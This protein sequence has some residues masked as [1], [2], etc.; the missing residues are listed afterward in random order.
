MSEL[1]IHWVREA[2][3]RVSILFPQTVHLDSLLVLSSS[4][5]L[6]A[7]SDGLVSGDNLIFYGPKSPELDILTYMQ[8]AM[9]A[10]DRCHRE[11]KTYPS[12]FGKGSDYS[13]DY[14]NP[15]TA[16][17]DYPIVTKLKLPTQGFAD[18]NQ[19]FNHLKA[20]GSWPGEPALY[21][22]SINCCQL[23]AETQTSFFE[24]FIVHGCNRSGR[25][26]QGPDGRALLLVSERGTVQELP[27]L[28]SGS[29]TGA[30]RLCIWTNSYSG[31]GLFLLMNRLC[32]FYGSLAAVY[33]LL[34]KLFK[35][36]KSKITAAL[37]GFAMLS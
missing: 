10:A 2:I 37:I 4:T 11:E 30:T 14:V 17:V 9:V 26:F 20:G 28:R 7:R 3:S 24:D 8:N 32:L 25:I 18:R 5:W 27:P 6:E 34:A 22:G 23:V 29:I 35:E 21:P 36:P 1:N 19:F 13:F 15:F 31:P 33:L 12:S 16:R